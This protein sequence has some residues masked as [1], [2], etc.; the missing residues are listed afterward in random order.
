V[1]DERCLDKHNLPRPDVKGCVGNISKVLRRVGYPELGNR[2]EKATLC[3]I[4][5]DCI[6]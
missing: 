5:C 6:S 4:V 2:G 3:V 1:L